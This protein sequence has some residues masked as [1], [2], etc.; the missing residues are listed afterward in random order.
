VT[1]GWHETRVPQITMN[2]P[3]GAF[4]YLAHGIKQAV[5]IPVIGCNRINN[6]DVAEEI[7]WE[8]KADFIGMARPLIADPELP[9]KAMNGQFDTIRPCIGCNQ[10]CFDNIMARKPVR[11]LVNAEAGRETEL[12]FSLSTK[13]DNAGGENK[14]A[15]ADRV[16]VVGAGPAGMEFARVAAARGQR[17]TIWEECEQPGG[18]LA[19]AAAPPGRADFLYFGTY[20]ANACEELGVEIRYGVRANTENIISAVEEGNFDKVVIATGARP[21]TPSIPIAP[22]AAVVQAWDVLA[23]RSK[24]GQK[25]V[26]IGGGAVGVET[27]LLLARAGALDNETLRFL[28]LHRAEQEG[29][30]YRLLTDGS[31]DITILEMVKGIGRDIGVSTRWTLLADLRRHRVKCLDKTTV[32]E[33]NREGVFVEN[34]GNEKVIPADTVVFAAGSC[35]QNELYKSLQDKIADLRM[36]GDAVKPRKVLD[37]VHEAY[38]NALKL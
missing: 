27:A 6:L 10:G 25:V 38:T 11:C 18:Q 13:W 9:N 4:V 30:L 2:V 34:E 20:L 19:L 29:E 26:I 15:A 8:G 35:S 32:L 24:T 14:P 3:P 1:G 36:I 21:I 23:G 7:L 28:M 37:A 31:K 5:S 12:A 16:L 17:V 33:V 22:G